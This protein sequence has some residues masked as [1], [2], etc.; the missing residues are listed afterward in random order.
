MTPSNEI[1]VLEEECGAEPPGLHQRVVVNV[2]LVECPLGT[3]GQPEVVGAQPHYDA[4]GPCRAGHSVSQVQSVLPRTP[5]S[6]NRAESIQV[7]EAQTW[8]PPPACSEISRE[9]GEQTLPG[10]RDSHQSQ[11]AVSKAK[12]VKGVLVPSNT[13]TRCAVQDTPAVPSKL[14]V[15]HK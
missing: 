10:L 6:E 4:R 2:I 11:P 13:V 7:A 8:A 5:P 3:G 1:F 12:G 9:S 14:R 15:T